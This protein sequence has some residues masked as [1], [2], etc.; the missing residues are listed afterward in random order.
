MLGRSE[1]IIDQ[2]NRLHGMADNLHEVAR[3]ATDHLHDGRPSTLGP[4]HDQAAASSFAGLWKLCF[5]PTFVSDPCKLSK[6]RKGM[7][8]KK[9]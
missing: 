4:T 1:I 5:A 6:G 8:G 9:R 2:R 3:M 7:R